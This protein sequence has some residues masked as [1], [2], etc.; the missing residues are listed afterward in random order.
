[1]QGWS[2]V[3][4]AVRLAHDCVDGAV[5]IS[6]QDMAAAKEAWRLRLYGLFDETP[7]PFRPQNGG[8]YPA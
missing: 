7:F 4:S 6:A 1:M 8:D 5:R 2:R 3:P